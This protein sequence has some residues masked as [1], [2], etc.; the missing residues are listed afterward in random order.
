MKITLYK[1]G[2]KIKTITCD[3]I[4][5]ITGNKEGQGAL[6]LVKETV[7]KSGIV[8]DAE[9]EMTASFGEN[10]ITLEQPVEVE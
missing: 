7:N 9:N 3:E 10:S 5:I 1:N 8:I 6:F 4:D 2:K